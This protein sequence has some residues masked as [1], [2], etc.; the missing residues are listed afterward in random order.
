MKNRSVIIWEI[1]IVGLTLFFLSC[2]SIQR[3][4]S[5]NNIE[6]EEIA[7]DVVVYYLPK[8]VIKAHFIL[9]EVH[10]IPGPYASY[11]KEMIGVEP[12]ILTE[13]RSYTLQPN[14]ISLS[15]IPDTDHYYLVQHFSRSIAGKPVFNED[16]LLTGFNSSSP[17]NSKLLIHNEDSNEVTLD[18]RGDSRHY[19][20]GMG[21]RIDTT[22]RVIRNDSL[23]IIQQPVLKKQSVLRSDKE[24]AA[25]L[26]N[27]M[28]DLY[29]EKLR[30]LQGDKHELPDGKAFE[31]VFREYEVIENKYLPLFYGTVEESTKK[32]EFEFIPES[33]WKDT[34]ILLGYFSE[35]AGL[36]KDSTGNAKPL[37]IRYHVLAKSEK[38]DQ[39]NQQMDSLRGSEE[40][41]FLREPA[42][43]SLILELGEEVITIYKTRVAQSGSIYR[44]P[45]GDLHP[46]KTILSLDPEF[47]SFKGINKKR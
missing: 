6:N 45:I 31:V 29:Q 8:N 33:A 34:S 15:S 22:Y 30:I 4:I 23:G 9:K 7:E 43:V 10:Q 26:A 47:G 35:E 36:K 46:R 2:G 28:L 12:Q 18:I 19:V 14:G 39:L 25:D 27:T 21:E 42:M 20:K 44:Y 32:L 1:A 11:S 40:I 24:K 17:K 16:G 41:L 37:S 38:L 13:N 3:T 5:L